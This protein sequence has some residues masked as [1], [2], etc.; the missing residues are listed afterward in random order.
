MHIRSCLTLAGILIAPTA[1][2]GGIAQTVGIKGFNYT[3]T[4]V[5]IAPGQTVDFTAS[6]FHPLRLDDASV[7]NCTQDCNVTYTTPGSYGFYCGN[8]GGVGGV[9]MSGVVQVKD[10]PESAPVFVGT[11]EHTLLPAQ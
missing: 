11:F 5:A 6:G 3:P 2:A 7:V 1:V 4:V 9:G 8:H 10:D